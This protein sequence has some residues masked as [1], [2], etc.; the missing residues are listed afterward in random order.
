[1]E[2]QNFKN[3]TRIV[4]GFHLI[5]FAILL[6]ILIG[7][8]VNIYHAAPENRY[9]AWLIFS[10]VI[11]LTLTAWYS[12]VFPLKAQD[13]AIR[14]EENFRHFVLTGKPLD[15]NLRMSQII[16]LR[17]AS[18]EEFLVLTKKAVSE[19]LSSKEIKGAIQNWKG[20]FHR[21]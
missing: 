5:L 2:A 18:D 17:F 9:S 4:T 13:R 11:A 14:A 12:R 7:S 10:L 6:A 3:H 15:S 19:N 20:D 1:M 21:A 16:A 8:M